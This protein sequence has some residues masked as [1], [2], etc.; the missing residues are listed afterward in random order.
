[1]LKVRFLVPCYDFMKLKADVLVWARVTELGKFMFDLLESGVGNGWPCKYVRCE[2]EEK[3]YSEILQYKDFQDIR[4]VA[5]SKI[6]AVQ[7][8]KDRDKKVAKLF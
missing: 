8:L 7:R 1:M 2:V 6:L 5:A 3:G 4:D